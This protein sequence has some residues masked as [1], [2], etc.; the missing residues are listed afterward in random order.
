MCVAFLWKRCWLIQRRVGKECVR[1]HVRTTWVSG[2]G[3]FRCQRSA[4]CFLGLSAQASSPP[5]IS[6]CLAG[7]L[8]PKQ[9]HRRPPA[10]R[11]TA[12]TSLTERSS[13]S[14]APWPRR[15]GPHFLR[16]A[17]WQP[18]CLL[19]G[20]SCKI[21][22]HCSLGKASCCLLQREPLLCESAEERVLCKLQQCISVFMCMCVRV[23][24]GELQTLLADSWRE[25]NR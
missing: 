7:S 22:Y 20:G 19:I 13:L 14:A 3:G 6:A 25:E 12:H 11:T 9:T 16:R 15:T 10:S 18:H 8:S 2:A 5:P 23:A 21:S 17:H 4:A 1:L 24:G